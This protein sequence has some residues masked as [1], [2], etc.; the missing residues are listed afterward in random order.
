M[1]FGVGQ[2]APRVEDRRLTTGRGRYTDDISLP[3]QVRAVMLRSP[4]PHARIRSIGTRAAKQIEGV[5]DIFTG[6]DIFAANV[7]PL[8]TIASTMPLTRPDGS[9][10]H[11]PNWW[12]LAVERVRFVGDGGGDGR[13]RDAG[14]GDGGGGA[15]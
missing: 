8:P 3:G 13:C 10:I 4:H 9:P 11:I 2:S 5:L 1:K 6:A 12:P 7:G 15:H 14:S